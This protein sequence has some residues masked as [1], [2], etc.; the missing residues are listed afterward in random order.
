MP[1]TRNEWHSLMS[2]FTKNANEKN[3]LIEF[4]KKEVREKEEKKIV[5][6]FNNYVFAETHYLTISLIPRSY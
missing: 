2:T 1:T 4:P 5:Y 6:S 3:T